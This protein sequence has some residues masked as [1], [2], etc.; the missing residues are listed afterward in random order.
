MIIEENPKSVTKRGVK[1]I[2][3]ERTPLSIW[4]PDAELANGRQTRFNSFTTTDVINKYF[5]SE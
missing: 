2:E 5:D 3:N 1:R 4:L